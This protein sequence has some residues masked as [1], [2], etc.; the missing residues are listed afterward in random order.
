MDCINCGKNIEKAHY[1]SKYCSDCKKIKIHEAKSKYSDKMKK[2]INL[3][4]IDKIDGEIWKNIIGNEGYMIS[5]KGRV[6]GKNGLLKPQINNNGY[7]CVSLCR[8]AKHSRYTIHRL[9]ALHFIDNPDNLEWVDHI[10]RNRQNNEITNLRWVS[11]SGNALNSSKHINRRG[12]IHMST[13]MAQNGKM[14]TYVKFNYSDSTG[15]RYSKNFDTVE[16]AEEYQKKIF[17]C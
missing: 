17:P 7:Y 11:P 16:Q 10:D 1:N 3:D 2:R 9:I 13:S 14:Y 15:M 12:C 8:E 6:I 5:N 4:S